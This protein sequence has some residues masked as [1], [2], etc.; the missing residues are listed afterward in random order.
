MTVPPPLEVGADEP[1]PPQQ[2]RRPRHRGS[3]TRDIVEV[4]LLALA[5]Y[6]I[7]TFALQTVRVDGTSMVPTLQND[8]LLFAD[9]VT[10]HLHAPNRG[11][12][13]ILIPPDDP[14][15]DFIKRVV[16]VPGDQ[17]R[18]LPDYTGSDGK[19]RSAV[20]VKPNGQ[21]AWQVLQEP[22]LP[23]QTTDPWTQQSSCCAPDGKY[24][25]T[26]TAITIPQDQFFVMG[27]NRNAS[28]DSRSIGMIPRDHILGRAWLR[29]WPLGHFGFL[30]SGPTLVTA[31]M[32]PFG[33]LRLRRRLGAL[34]RAA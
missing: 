3:I 5:L 26:P 2:R 18:I 29:I 10:Y 6:V 1:G 27:D 23:D 28:K 11:D 12:I 15:K 4:L 7:I 24:S 14:G 21:G 9:K 25:A 22:Y 30:G 8:D 17:L 33:A 34:R 32:L 20:E 31:I 19:A 13:I 16:G